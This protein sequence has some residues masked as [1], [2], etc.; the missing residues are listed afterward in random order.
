MT[1]ISSIESVG[2]KIL[3]FF[4]ADDAKGDPQG[5]RVFVPQFQLMPVPY[6]EL[7]EVLIPLNRSWATLNASCI[8]N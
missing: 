6:E 2:I 8:T 4:N 1:N 7:D 5:R 3:D